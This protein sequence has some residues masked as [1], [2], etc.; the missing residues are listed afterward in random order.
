MAYKPLI[1]LA[2]GS[3]Y[4]GRLLM[5]QLAP[6]YHF[7]VLGRYPRKLARSDYK[8]YPKSPEEAAALMEGAYAL[9]NLAGKSVDCRYTEQNKAE[10]MASRVDTTHYLAHAIQHCVQPPKVWVNISSAT[11]YPDSQTPQREVSP[12]PGGNFSE[13]VCLAW[14]NAFYNEETPRTRKVALR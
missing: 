12:T 5:E 13:E 10:I 8:V 2:G 1:V 9:I 3:G 14:E 4:L 7:L 11:I 6:Y